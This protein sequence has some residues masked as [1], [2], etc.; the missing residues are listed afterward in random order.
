MGDSI[1]IPQAP[2]EQGIVDLIIQFSPFLAALI[3]V[4][5]LVW[6]WR[7]MVGRTIIIVSITAFIVLALA[8]MGA[9]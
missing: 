6:A 8:K 2:D 3:L 9:F 1:P 5:I 7:S 4:G